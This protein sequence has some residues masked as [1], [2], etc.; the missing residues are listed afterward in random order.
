MILGHGYWLF[1][2]WL[3]HNDAILFIAEKGDCF[4][5]VNTGRPAAMSASEAF[6]YVGHGTE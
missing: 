4:R 2:A 6:F 3:G 1:G 5:F